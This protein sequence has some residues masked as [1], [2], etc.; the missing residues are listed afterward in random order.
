MKKFSRRN[1]FSLIGAAIFGL[2]RW[3]KWFPPVVYKS[4]NYNSKG[5]VSYKYFYTAVQLEGPK[6]IGGTYRFRTK[7]VGSRLG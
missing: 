7:D 2:Q 6:G 1:W 3:N 5:I 4:L